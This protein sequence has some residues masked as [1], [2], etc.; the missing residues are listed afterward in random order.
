[1]WQLYI[2]DWALWVFVLIFDA[3]FCWM[4]CSVLQSAKAFVRQDLSQASVRNVAGTK[5]YLHDKTFLCTYIFIN[6]GENFS[7]TLKVYLQ[8]FYWTKLVMHP[9]VAMTNYHL[10]YNKESSMI[11]Q[12]KLT[13][14]YISTKHECIF[15]QALLFLFIL[16]E[17]EDH[18]MN[19][20]TNGKCFITYSRCLM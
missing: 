12:E 3:L 10:L 4:A 11:E 9:V 7:P 18:W 2:S 16:N 20:P 6:P 15:L 1:M 14:Y 13:N 19:F 5:S 17:D 8:A